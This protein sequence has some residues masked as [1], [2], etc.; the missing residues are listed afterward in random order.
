MQI[1]AF[2][3]ETWFS[4]K[5]CNDKSY[6]KQ[7]NQNK[8][9]TGRFHALSCDTYTNILP[10]KASLSDKML[11]LVLNCNTLHVI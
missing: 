3:R 4:L 11:V 10:D 8:G 9:L 6:F 5:L 7:L 1:G 2:S